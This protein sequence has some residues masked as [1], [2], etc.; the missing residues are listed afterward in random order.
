[1]MALLPSITAMSLIKL[2]A[3]VNALLSYDLA[4]QKRLQQ[5]DQ[6]SLN[7]AIENWGINLIVRVEQGALAIDMKTAETTC[8]IKASP[9]TLK[10]IAQ[11]ELSE[12]LRNNLQ[13]GGSYQTISDF[14]CLLTA[15]NIDWASLLS[16]YVPAFAVNE[17]QRKKNAIKATIMQKCQHLKQDWQDHQKAQASRRP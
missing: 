7:W 4:A 1:M 8:F 6:Q 14:A 12:D 9:Q 10:K 11:D 2:D 3:V 5:L 16:D 15:P 13:V 17:A